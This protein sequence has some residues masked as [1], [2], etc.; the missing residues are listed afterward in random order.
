MNAE[1]SAFLWSIGLLICDLLNL[2]AMNSSWY[3]F[4]TPLVTVVYVVLT[5]IIVRLSARKNLVP[6]LFILLTLFTSVFLVFVYRKS[7]ELNTAMMWMS[8]AFLTPYLGMTSWINSDYQLL[9][10]IISVINTLLLIIFIFLHRPA[11]K[12]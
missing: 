1:I 7:V 2:K 3:G 6:V 10:I 11:K 12:Q 8:I 5:F 4:V 9:C